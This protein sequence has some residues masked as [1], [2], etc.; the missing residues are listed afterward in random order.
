MEYTEDNLILLQAFDPKTGHELE[1]TFGKEG[2]DAN[3]LANQKKIVQRTFI[4]N[5]I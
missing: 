1:K 2:M 3:Y 5:I 4:N